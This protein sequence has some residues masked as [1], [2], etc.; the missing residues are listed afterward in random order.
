VE[1]FLTSLKLKFDSGDRTKSRNNIFHY[2]G[3]KDGEQHSKGR[4]LRKQLFESLVEPMNVPMLLQALCLGNPNGSFNKLLRHSWGLSPPARLLFAIESQFCC[5]LTQQQAP[6]K[7]DSKFDRIPDLIISKSNVLHN[8]APSVAFGPNKS[9]KLI[10]SLQIVT[11]P[12]GLSTSDPLSFDQL[13]IQTEFLLGS[14]LHTTDRRSTVV[15]PTEL[16]QVP[17]QGCLPKLCEA[18]FGSG[19]SS[20]VAAKWNCV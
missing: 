6:S 7:S 10:P 19:T 1:A 20:H 9:P 8:V 14:G 13:L 17:Q 4:W 16:G 11:L 15:S 5:L 3:W 2:I 12:G 18:D